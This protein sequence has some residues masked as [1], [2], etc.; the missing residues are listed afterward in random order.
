MIA[1]DEISATAT[2]LEFPSST[3]SRSSARARWGNPAIPPRRHPDPVVLAFP[4]RRAI[5]SS[6]GPDEPPP[7]HPAKL[8]RSNHE[9][10]EPTP[11]VVTI[12]F[13][14]KGDTMENEIRTGT[15]L[16]EDD[17]LLPETLRS[18]TRPYSRVWR[19]VHGMDRDSLGRQ[20]E[21]AGWTFFYTEGAI[22]ATAIGL[23]SEKTLHRTIGRVIAKLKWDKFNCL[24]VTRVVEKRMFGFSKVTVVACWRLLGP[25]LASTPEL[26]L[27]SAALFRR[28]P[29]AVEQ[30]RWAA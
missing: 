11:Q 16:I 4:A 20:I 19:L 30:E 25:S 1:T 13:P 2:I 7:K 15:I 18:Q 17:A 9:M 12:Q 3:D 28:R 22:T 24:E 14:H 29:V 21:Q 5:G 27:P 10:K 23:D 6:R 26:S 8:K